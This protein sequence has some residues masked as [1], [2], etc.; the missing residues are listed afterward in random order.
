MNTVITDKTINNMNN[1]MSFAAVTQDVSFSDL[2][3]SE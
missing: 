2:V 1:K 3:A